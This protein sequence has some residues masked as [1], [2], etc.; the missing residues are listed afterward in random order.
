MLRAR[1]ST[2]QERILRS[3]LGRGEEYWVE[4][5]ENASVMETELSGLISLKE[6]KW[7]RVGQECLVEDCEEGHQNYQ[8]LRHCQDQS[9]SNLVKGWVQICVDC[10][11][12]GQ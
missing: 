5:G 10:S 2:F 7:W 1:P 3:M 8:L 6:V 9:E 12:Q 11:W 4:E